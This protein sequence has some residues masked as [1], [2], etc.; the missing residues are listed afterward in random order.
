MDQF[1][2]QHWQYF[3]TLS[4]SVVGGAFALWRFLLTRHA[5]LAWRR[6]QFVFEQAGY[7]ESDPELS[8]V[9]KLLANNHP[10]AS[11]DDVL[12]ED[13]SLDDEEVLRLKYALDKFLNFFDRMYY[14]VHVVCTLRLD[15]LSVFS[16]YLDALLNEPGLKTYCCGNGYHDVIRLA[17]EVIHQSE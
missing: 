9:L 3:L 12:D 1:L 13:T 10:G 17:E 7:L 2:S 8:E 5:E 14:A 15:E 4:V 11:L 16:W 6:T